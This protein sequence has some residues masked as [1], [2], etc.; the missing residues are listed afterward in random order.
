MEFENPSINRISISLSTHFIDFRR[1]RKIHSK[2]IRIALLTPDLGEGLNSIND[3][4]PGELAWF[5]E[6]SDKSINDKS[7]EILFKND[8]FILSVFVFSLY[9]TIIFVYI[10]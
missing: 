9:F 5:S 7:Y 10:G 1:K 8:T 6:S 3:L 4:K 2:I